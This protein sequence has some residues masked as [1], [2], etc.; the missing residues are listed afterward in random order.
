MINAIDGQ[1]VTD[2]NV[3]YTVNP[4]PD[5]RTDERFMGYSDSESHEDMPDEQRLM[6]YLFRNYEKTVRPVRNAST[7]VEI[8]MGLTMAQIFDMVSLLI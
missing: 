6:R 1:G 5:L 4:G 8:R 7:A 2:E 3:N